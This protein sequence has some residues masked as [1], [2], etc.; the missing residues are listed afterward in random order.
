[1]AQHVDHHRRL[2]RVAGAERDRA[3][4]VAPRRDLARERLPEPAELRV[5]DA[6]QRLRGELGDAARVVDDRAVGRR[7]GPVVGALHEPHRRARRAAARAARRRSGARSSRVSAS[8]KTITSPR[9]TDSAR[10]IASPLPTTGPE[11]GHQLRLVVAPPPRRCAPPRR[12]RRPSARRSPEAGRRA[13]PARAARRPRRG[14]APSVGATSRVG[15]TRLTDRPSSRLRCASAPRSANCVVPVRARLEPFARGRSGDVPHGRRH[16]ASTVT[17]DGAESW[18][19]RARGAARGRG[20]ATGRPRPPAGRGRPCGRRSRTSSTRT[21]ARRSPR[22]ASTSLYSHQADAWES[23][24]RRGHTIVTTGTASGKSLCFNLPVLHMLAVRP[25]RAGALPVSDQGARPGPGAQPD[26]AAHAR[27]APRDLRRRHAAGGAC[28]RSAGAR[29]S[30]SRTRTCCTSA[31]CPTTPAGATSSRT[32]R[33]WSWTRR[34]STAACSART[35]RTCCA[36]CGGSP[37]PTERRPRFVLTSATIAN[38]LSLA[39]ELTGLEFDLVDRDGS[40]RGEREV[41]MCNPPLLDERTRRRASSLSEAANL[42]ADLV[43]A[44][45]RTI[46]FA[47]SRRAA[48]LIYQFA[49]TRLEETSDHAGA[50]HSLP[51]RLHAAAAARDRA[52]PRDAASCSAWSRR[53]RSSSESTS[54]TSTR[55]CRSRSRARSRACASSGGAPG[56]RERGGLA[57]YVA[58][59]DALD[60]FFCRH[61]EEFLERRGRGR[62]PRPLLRDAST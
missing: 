49:R 21:C 1:M 27:A 9:A 32:S 39:R 5:E 29:T 50:H 17:D 51:R 14:S 52:A 31:S 46:C 26:R 24:M 35:S 38:P 59:D 3:Q 8:A 20:R 2:D 4:Q 33:S 56:A 15:R 34:T 18:T 48:E 60:Q 57:M 41:V 22:A 58:G 54:A 6:E 11:R 55:R 42:F 12:C 44:E 62:D 61:P 37:T 10:H 40:E 19:D 53:T 7:E 47:R 13:A 30:C 16:R 25:A 23:V 36:G 28:A 43:A 45:V